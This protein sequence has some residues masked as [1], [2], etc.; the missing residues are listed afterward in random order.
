MK[1]Y[2]SKED[3]EGNYN[4]G[5]DESNCL[6][7]GQL[8]SLFCNIWGNEQKWYTKSVDSVH[9]ANFLKLDCSKSKNKLKWHPYLS[10]EESIKYTIDWY[11]TFEYNNVNIRKIT[12]KQ[13]DDYLKKVEEEDFI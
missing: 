10:I 5:P 11:K 9:E 2:N 4:F 6:T 3:Y 13:I 12:K 1:Q 7:T 8:V